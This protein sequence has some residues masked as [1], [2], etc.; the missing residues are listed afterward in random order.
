MGWIVRYTPV[1]GKRQS[2]DFFDDKDKAIKFAEQLNEIGTKFVSD[3]TVE[4]K[5]DK[6]DSNWY[7]R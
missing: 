1:R 6:G 3:V 4:H 2:Q 5:P 7:F